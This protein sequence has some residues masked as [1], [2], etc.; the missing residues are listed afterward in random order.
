MQIYPTIQYYFGTEKYSNGKLIPRG[1]YYRYK[2][3]DGDFHLKKLYDWII[4]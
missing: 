2:D 4:S 3:K 1:Y